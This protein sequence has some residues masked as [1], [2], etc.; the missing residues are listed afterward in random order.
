MGLRQE[1]G[2][3]EIPKNCGPLYQR[4]GMLT[5]KERELSARQDLGG[6][7]GQGGVGPSLD[8]SNLTHLDS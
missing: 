5:N 8:D 6:R 2:D 4:G 1:D 3:P 7:V